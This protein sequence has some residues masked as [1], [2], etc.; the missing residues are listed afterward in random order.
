MVCVLIMEQL[1]IFLGEHK[2]D[3]IA[4]VT[5][6]SSWSLNTYWELE[7]QLAVIAKSL[8]VLASLVFVCIQLY[9]GF[10]YITDDIKKRRNERR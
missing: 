5:A 4:M 2:Y 10:R 9:K 1:K 3:I 7:A 8:T 6:G